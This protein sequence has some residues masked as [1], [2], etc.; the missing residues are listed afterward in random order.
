MN[1]RRRLW[2]WGTFGALLCMIGVVLTLLPV[3]RGGRSQVVPDRLF[4][5]PIVP[6]SLALEPIEPEA[7]ESLEEEAEA[8]LTD[9]ALAQMLSEAFGTPEAATVASVDLAS[10]STEALAVDGLDLSSWGTGQDPRGLGTVQQQDLALPG[11]T[12][13]TPRLAPTLVQ[14]EVS[15]SGGSDLRWTLEARSDTTAPALTTQAVARRAPVTLEDFSEVVVNDAL[16]QWIVAAPSP[17]DPG[18]QSLFGAGPEVHTARHVVTV[19]GT[20]FELQLMLAPINGEIRVVLIQQEK[21]YYFV[22]P[23]GQQQASYFQVGTIRR[24]AQGRIVTVESEDLSPQG[25]EAQAFYRLFVDWWHA[26]DP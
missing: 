2:E 8:A 18:I 23:R 1:T 26:Q 12:R 6:P 22:S 17:L 11:R 24:D 9:D 4:F 16:A 7:S 10:Q 3:P 19:A 25:A 21:L 15:G 14:P 20:P 13:S 5:L